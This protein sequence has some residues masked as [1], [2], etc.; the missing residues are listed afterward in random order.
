MLSSEIDCRDIVVIEGS[1]NAH[2]V[3]VSCREIAMNLSKLLIFAAVI[4]VVSCVPKS[5]MRENKSDQEI[6]GVAKAQTG[7]PLRPADSIRI[8]LERSK[9]KMYVFFVANFDYAFEL[10]FDIVIYPDG[11]VDILAVKTSPPMSPELLQDFK[12][13]LEKLDFGEGDYAKT[14]FTYTLNFF[15]E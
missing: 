10:T 11:S 2:R 7:S 14:K 9:G 4:L 13:I 6:S 12:A 15:L 3:A 1:E 8:L 5:S